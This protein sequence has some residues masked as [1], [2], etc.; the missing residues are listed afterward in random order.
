MDKH[1][2]ADILNEIAVLL[3]LKGE[4]VFKTRAYTNGARALDNLEEPLEVLI[5]EGRLGDIKGFG[6]ALVEKITVLVTEGSLKYYDDLKASIPPGHIEMLDINGLG[7]KKIVAI[8]KALRVDTIDELEK[9][10]KEGKVAELDGFGA[11]SQS[12]ILEGIEHRRKYASRHLISRTL[13]ISEDILE[14][15]RSH[16]EVIRCSL[17]GSQRR[18]RETIGDID[19]LVSSS[20][21]CIEGVPGFSFVIARREELLKAEGIALS[22]SLDLFAQW[23]GLE[24]NGQFRF[25]PPTHALLAFNQALKELEE[26]GGVVARAARYRRN[27][28]ILLVGMRELGFQEYVPREHQGWIITTFLYPDDPAFDFN[29]FYE[30]L[31]ARG[32]VIYPGKLTELDCF[33]IGNIGRLDESHMRALLDAIKEVALEMGL[34]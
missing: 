6:K 4:N 7:P 17:A 26:E 21:K 16:P 5:E 13:P 18:H 15:L 24:R 14:D 2:V 27:H 34:R 10:C 3:E 20:N 28:E 29:A 33:R 25:T 22:V 32:M 8:H 19:F 9:A 23:E 31:S 1:E 30:N 12:K 11:K